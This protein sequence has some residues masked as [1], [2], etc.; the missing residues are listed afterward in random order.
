M[1]SKGK[2]MHVFFLLGII[3]L[4][5]TRFLFPESGIYDRVGIIA[6]HGMHGAVP[7]ENIDLFTGNLTL[8]FQDIRLP[9]PNGFDTV[10]WRVYNSKI[11]R[12]RLPGS[13]WGMQQEP[14]SCV[15]MGWS[16]HMGRVHNFNSSEPVIEFPDGRWET[17]YPNANGPDYIT[18]GFL[19]YDKNNYKL[20]FKDGTVWTFGEEKTLQYLGST[21]QVRVVTRIE[22]SY[23]HAVTIQYQSGSSPN[24]YKV[25]DSMNRVI[26][27]VVGSNRLTRIYLKNVTGTTINYYYTVGTFSQGG[28][29][30]L[31]EYNPPE[32]DSSTYEYYSGLYDHYELTAVNTSYGGR[33]EYEY[34]DHTFYYQVQPLQTRVVDRKRIR[35][36]SSGSLQTWN[37]NYPDYYN[38]DTGTVLVDGPVFNTNVTYHALSSA[39]P[40]EN[41]W[42]IGLLKKKQFTDSSYS[43]EHDWTY[44]QISTTIW[45]V[46]NID[47]GPIRA[48]LAERVIYSRKGDCES[49]EK[50]LYQRTDVKNYGLPTKIEYYGGASGTTLKSY[51]TLQYYFETSSTFRSKYMV[52]YIKT[53]K[54]YSSGGSKLN[55]TQ[56]KYYTTTGKCGALDEVKKWR[57]GTTYLTWDYTY[58]GSNPNSITITVNL[59]GTAGIETYKYSYG[60]LSQIKRPGYTYPE[61][62]RSISSHN[63]AISS[64]TNQHGGTMNFTYDNLNR[65]KKI[66]ISSAAFNDIYVS[67][68]DNSVVIKQGG[69]TITKYWDGM[70]RDTGYKESG[71]GISL[72]YR[73]T[74]DAE[75]RVTAESRGSTSSSH[76]YSYQRNASGNPTRITDPRGKITNITYSGDQKTVTDAESNQAVFYYEGLPGLHTK[77]KDPMDR[78]AYYTYDGTGRLTR[79]NYNNA[80]TQTY[81]YNGLDQVTYES[82][83]ETG[84]ISYT[85]NSANN[86]YKKTW[87]TVTLTYTYNSANQLKRISTGT[88][89]E[90]IDYDYDAR[91]RLDEIDSNWGWERDQITYNSLG[92]LKTER[93]DIP[94]LGFKSLSYGYSGNNNLKSVTYSNGKRANYTNNSL[95]RHETASFN[96]KS[97]VSQASY[98]I[99]KQ[100][101]SMTISGNST[102]FTASYNS[103]GALSSTSLKKGATTH[104]R[105][106]YGYDNVGNITSISNTVPGLNASFIYDDLYRLRS[107][108]Y[109]GGKSC[110]YTYDYYGNLKTAKENGSTIFSRTYTTKNRINS[111]AFSY[112]TRGNMTEAPG[113]LYE[114]D[115]QNRLDSIKDAGSLLISTHLYNERG[116]RLRSRRLP[117]PAITVLSPN[118]GEIWYIGAVVDVTWTG[119]GIVGNVKI[120]YSINNGSSWTEIIC[121]HEQ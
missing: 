95:N 13:A 113:F 79:V 48:P 12:D 46:L 106:N 1:I 114:W 55:E 14:Y 57:S 67:W 59:P 93:Q 45:R 83:P 32:I 65:I 7:E 16:M 117:D 31:T 80:R 53:G 20:Y 66:D 119:S 2:A 8:R 104:Y 98:S 105:A 73:K 11:M 111:T 63:S 56:T 78:Y 69:N 92:S 108:A 29:Y 71:D 47:L 120:E 41:G 3:I 25:T 64:E 91:A 60:I 74:P 26:T 94:G 33:M 85:Y 30:K 87:G 40:Y 107:A 100:P 5:S 39:N 72:Y 77:L 109:T 54:T 42:K 35:F 6:E 88:G 34:V 52:D 18:R 51:K 101:T 99:H 58:T 115:R 37:Y 15:G 49:R 23:G 81:G 89:S 84:T 70:G 86:L 61:L 90:F 21:A 62:S 97:L 44:R 10:V 116:L 38:A 50:Y 121:F 4:M 75:G 36:T 118:G 19:E 68:Y 28:Y 112:D 27:F 43:E 102:T 110:N 76:Q 9:G 17:A 22:N 82:H 103:I 96:S 24:L